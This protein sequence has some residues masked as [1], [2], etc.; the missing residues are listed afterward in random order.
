M[1]P[2][3]RSFWE[4]RLLRGILKNSSYLFS[5]NAAAIIL[6]I[7]QQILVARLLGAKNFGILIATIIPFVSNIHRL[8]SF[9]MSETIVRYY[10]SA[11]EEGKKNKAAAIVKV[12]IMVEAATSILTFTT[13]ALLAPLAARWFAQDLQ[14]KQLFLLYGIHLLAYFSYETATGVLQSG[15]LFNQ[16]AFV[17]LIQSLITAGLILLAFLSKGG[18]LQVI[19]AYL[20]GKSFAGLAVAWLALQQLNQRLS[21]GWWRTP[22]S[23]LSNRGELLRFALSTNIN[24]TMN[25]VVR[26]SETLLISLL[27][28]PIESGYF[29]IALGAINLVMLP[30]EPFINPTYTELANTITQRKFRDAQRILKR[31]SLISALWTFIAGGGLALLGWWVIPWV[32]GAEYLPAYPAVA[33][34][35]VGYG[36]ANILHWNRPLLLALGIPTFPLK[37]S[38]ITGAIKTTLTLFLLPTFGYIAEAIILSTYFL[39]SIGA[40]VWHGLRELSQRMI[41]ANNLVS[42][43]GAG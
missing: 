13:L 18:M 12:A 41:A 3:I 19:L 36:F 14:T 33:L 23:E 7:L 17:N 43:P 28:S 24:V 16:L 32:Y 40:N 26:D 38:L 21:S 9:R 11:L 30:I 10:G 34:L 2:A 5:S 27:R 15:R 1:L 4:D 8:L 37:V 22:L 20:L 35:L 29:R 39:V 25:L 42:D 31:V 6:S